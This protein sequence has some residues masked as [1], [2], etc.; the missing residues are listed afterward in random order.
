MPGATRCPAEGEPV[1]EICRLEEVWAIQACAAGNV[2]IGGDCVP[3]PANCSP[4]QRICLADGRPAECA[5]GGWQPLAACAAGLVCG[6]GDCLN[7]QCAAAARQSSYQGCEYLAVDLPNSTLA[8]DGEGLTP[9]APWGIVIANVSNGGSA[10]VSIFD[11]AGAPVALVAST[12]IA[13]PLEAPPGTVAEQVQSEVRDA[14]G[15][16]VAQGFDRADLIEVPPGGLATFLLPRR[17]G[18]VAVTSIRTDAV[19]VVSD[20]P[21]VAYQFSPYCCN[22]SFS[23]DASLLVPVRALGQRYRW[24]GVPMMTAPFTSNAVISVVGSED[25]TDVTLTLPGDARVRADLAGRVRQVG[26]RV[27][28]RLAAQEVLLLHTESRGFLQPSTDLSGTL[29]ESSRP[30]AL[31]STHVCTNYPALLGA[32]D[33]LQEQIFPMD[34]WGSSFQL[35]PTKLRAPN[36]AG[37]VTYWK[38]MAGDEAATIR[39]GVPFAN[40]RATRPGFDGVAAC[41]AAVQNGDTIVLQPGAVCE[42]GTKV[43]TQITSSSPILVMGI[44]SGQ[45][46]TGLLGN[47]ARAGDPAIFLVPPDRQFRRDYTF[48]TPG[49]YFSDYVTVVSPPNND[50]LLDGVA[51]DLADAT[52][53]DGSGYVFKHVAL[54]DGAH[55]MQGR[56]PFGIVVYAYDNFVSYAFTGGLNLTK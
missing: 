25:E 50:L 8:V 9:S 53:I 11:A 29:V 54:D 40:L 37:E 20:A 19:R 51:V 18:P 7:P 45:E 22:Y 15:M 55:T 39:F 52:R 48:L 42:F 16:I 41:S 3:D 34:T 17:M 36:A 24:L 44:I 43:A 4:G 35:A 10:A 1:R 13:V 2:C 26:Q 5:G 6:A 27:N 14:N 49:T 56:A 23:N 33:H 30:V 32:C 46:S 21:V 28:V 47:N 12:R 31:F 38:L